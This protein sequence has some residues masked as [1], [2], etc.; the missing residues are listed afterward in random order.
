MFLLVLAWENYNS[1]VKICSV[2]PGFTVSWKELPLFWK[3]SFGMRYKTGKI[4]KY[5]SG[6]K[7]KKSCGSET[8]EKTNCVQEFKLMTHFSWKQKPTLAYR[9]EKMK[10]TIIWR[11]KHRLHEV[12]IQ[13]QIH[14]F[15]TVSHPTGMLLQVSSTCI[16]IS[17]AVSE[18]IGRLGVRS[19]S[20]IVNELLHKRLTTLKWRLV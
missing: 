18:S 15:P 12:Q 11:W 9:S 19:L 4:G 2:I 6:R 10:C 8:K 16:S 17:R 7:Q 3:L 5:I 13:I 14:Q 1:S 20:G